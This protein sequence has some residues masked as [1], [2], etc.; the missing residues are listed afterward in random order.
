MIEPKSRRGRIKDLQ[1]VIKDGGVRN[2]SVSEL[3]R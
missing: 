3:V 1:R 2:F